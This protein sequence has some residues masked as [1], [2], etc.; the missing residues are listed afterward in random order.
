[1]IELIK[2]FWIHF[3]AKKNEKSP[4]YKVFFISYFVCN[5][6]WFYLLFIQDWELF[7]QST[8]MTKYEY[9]I[10]KYSLHN[11]IILNWDNLFF[12]IWLPLL[13]TF[14]IFLVFPF[15]TDFI[16]KI[17]LKNKKSEETIRE[18]KKLEELEKKEIILQKEEQIEEK[19]KPKLLEWD[20]EYEEFKNDKELFESF[21]DIIMRIYNYW[22]SMKQIS[23]WTWL[24]SLEVWELIITKFVISDIIMKSS[25]SNDFFLTDKWIYFSKKYEKDWFLRDLEVTDIPF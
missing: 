11:W 6:K 17:H 18:D 5:W 13:L 1:M 24:F 25:N 19:E 22:W 12:T 15:I 8:Q 9:L 2:E 21:S 23:Y 14:M 3:K 16:L 20:K 4:F 10:E 7:F